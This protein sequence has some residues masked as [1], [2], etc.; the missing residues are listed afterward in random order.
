MNAP[1]LDF[2][3]RGITTRAIV[4]IGGGPA[5]SAA[6]ITLARAGMT[7]LVIERDLEPRDALCGGFLSWETIGRLQD[8]GVDPMALGAH[9]VTRL[10]IFA[11]ARHAEAVLPAPA[12]GLSRHALDRELIA[13]AK[14]AGAEILRGKAVRA[15]EK[16]R[17][18]IEGDGAVDADRI[19]LA[20]GKHEL[21][22]CRRS[23]ATEDPAIGLRWRLRAGP[24]LASLLDAR[25]ELHL[26]RDGYAGLIRQ[27]GDG[28]NLCLAIRR[29][30]LTEVGG[31]P[32]RLLDALANECPA[33]A[34]RLDRA[35]TIEPPQ[36]VANIPYGWRAEAGDSDLYRV[37]DQAAVIPSL[38]G[39]GIAIALASGVAAGRAITGDIGAA[40]YQGDLRRQLDIPF[41][42]SASLW[43]IAENRLGAA[44]IVA[45]V[46]LAP[47]LAT[48][49]GRWTRIG[50]G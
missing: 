21:R 46:R 14:A 9:Q 43:R 2:P 23:A 39:E 29:S 26:F 16:R 37:G 41:A 5:G 15:F 38:A 30:R 25:I 42:L 7:P 44:A 11:G 8:L 27:E 33:L 35:E 3:A 19:I 13:R 10:A 12:A 17:V 34:D 40:Q 36:A 20:T 6:A 28:A 18:L 31:R 47:A 32:E 50:D 24:A 1:L 4:V 48:S 22:G 45:A 49:L